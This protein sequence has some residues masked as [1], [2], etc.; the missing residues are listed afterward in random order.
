[1]YNLIFLFDVK[2]SA[3]D[4]AATAFY[5]SFPPTAQFSGSIATAAESS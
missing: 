2:L 1:M 3:I 4:S 5:L